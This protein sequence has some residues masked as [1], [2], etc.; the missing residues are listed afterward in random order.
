MKVQKSY[1]MQRHNGQNHSC[2]VHS[3]P[4]KGYGSGEKRCT[5][6]NLIL[7]DEYKLANG[8]LQAHETSAHGD[9]KESQTANQDGILKLSSLGHIAEPKNSL[10]SPEDNFDALV[11]SIVNDSIIKSSTLFVD[12]QYEY[13][14]G[15][16]QGHMNSSKASGCT[17]DTFQQMILSVNEESESGVEC[18]GS[19]ENF[20]EHAVQEIPEG[21]ELS[22]SKSVVGVPMQLPNI[23]TNSNYFN[24]L[25]SSPQKPLT[26][27]SRKKLLILD[28]NGLL[29]DIVYP[30]PKGYKADI[31]IAGRA[32]FKRPSCSDFLN[33]CFKRFDVGVWSSRSKRIVERVVHFLMGDVKHKLVF[34]W[35]L[36][37][38]TESNFRTLENRHK[39]LV[40]KELRKIWEKYDPNLPWEKG[41]FDE[42]NTLLLDDSPYK[43]LLNPPHTAVFP[44]SYD[45]KDHDDD[46]IGSGVI[47]ELIWKS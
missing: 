1:K 45:F 3:Y 2:L 40:F 43:A 47:F 6:S 31:K 24:L 42:S 18:L 19:C 37:H 36:S 29:A 23:S 5:E 13:A 34:C 39:K 14:K 27:C 4:E 21:A 28:I 46:S 7:S 10:L 17:S 8:K 25:H 20:G 11:A 38:C 30:P 9:L 44:Y 22:L 32:V 33:F 12:R 16:C 15:V 35:D 26:A 41:D